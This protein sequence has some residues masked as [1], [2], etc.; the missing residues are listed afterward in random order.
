MIWSHPGKGIR[1]TTHYEIFK[2][3][4]N[5]TNRGYY[6][7]S[8]SFSSQVYTTSFVK[9]NYLNIWV[10]NA[11]NESF[12][13]VSFA[14][15]GFNVASHVVEEIR[16]SEHT[17]LEGNRHIRIPGETSFAAD[18]S[19]QSLYSFKMKLENPVGG[20]D[21][22]PWQALDSIAMRRTLMLA[23]DDYSDGT[24]Q[25]TQQERFI[26]PTMRAEVIS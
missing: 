21:K 24:Y 20:I 19:P 26:C 4:V 23:P 5:N 6:I 18:I 16:W 17:L 11:S 10:L 12:D 8:G 13:S 15:E 1:K 3:L 14:L 22:Q 25:V 2:K 7:S 9:G